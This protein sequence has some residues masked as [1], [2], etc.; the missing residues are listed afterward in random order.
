MDKK[1]R[2]RG[3]FW[4]KFRRNSA[5]PTDACNWGTQEVSTW[6]EGLK[7]S[8]YADNFSSHDICGKELLSLTRRDFK[9]LGI[10]KLGHQLR[11]ERGIDEL[12]KSI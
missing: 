4:L 1:N 11:I 5:R 9:D 2:H 7:L 12:K 8:E 6:L 10:I 3:L